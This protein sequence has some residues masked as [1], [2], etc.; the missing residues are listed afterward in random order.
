M[1][2]AP[3]KR[4]VVR[5]GYVY[6]RQPLPVAAASAEVSI[7]TARRWKADAETAGD[8]WD[9]A[10]SVASLADTGRA[11]IVQGVIEEYLAL[12]QSTIESL[13]AA[14]DMPAL[15]R[16]EALSRLAD[17]FT[18]TMSAAAKSSPEMGRLAVATD[19]LQRL[20]AFVGRKAPQHAGAF[21][22]L[23]EPFAAELAKSYG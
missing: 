18:K 7:A 12:H 3:E 15:D 10:R 6:Q 8:D 1:A 17:A 19:V 9:R 13:K 4:A 21:L 5:A 2:H 23:L 16:A 11:T 20:T 22:D 14:T